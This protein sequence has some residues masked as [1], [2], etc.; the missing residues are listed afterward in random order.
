MRLRVNI[1]LKEMYAQEIEKIIINKR[2][3]SKQRIE[4]QRRL[5]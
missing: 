2:L 3:R 1:L 5:F 4:Q